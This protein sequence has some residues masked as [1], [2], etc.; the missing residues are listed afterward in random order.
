MDS[1]TVNLAGKQRML[2]QKIVKETLGL[3]Q[4]SVDTDTL[5]GTAASLFNKTLKGLI[6]GDSDLGLSA[7]TDRAILAQLTSVQRLWNIFSENINTD[8]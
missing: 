2:T 6:S 3:V 8:Y 5:K 7:T 4:R 1:K